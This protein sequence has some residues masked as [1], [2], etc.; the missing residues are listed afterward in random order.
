VVVAGST[1]AKGAR[2]VS[3]AEPI[4]LLGPP[5]PFASRGGHKLHAALTRFDVP[6]SGRRA[7]DLGAST[8]GFTDCLLQHGAA[9][10]YSVDVGHGQL[11]QRLRADSRVT[12]LERVNARLLTPALLHEADPDFEPCALVTADLS[13]ISL[14]T[15]TPTLCGPVGRPDADL[16]LLVKP[17]FEAGRG[18]V[19]RGRGV[20]RDPEVWLDVLAG[21]TSALRD[22]GTGI[23]GAMMSPLTGPAGNIEFL[24]HARKG[25]EG[26]PSGG[27]TALLSD[28]VSEAGGHP[29]PA[30]DPD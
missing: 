30:G 21:V 23:M 29:Q 9:H 5:S 17:Q 8:G 10:V 13:F 27:I 7:L 18:V 20:V 12:V 19:S 6:V 25:A 2:L 22:A 1:A 3:P 14:R 28:A 16:V 24:V 15:V 11:D 4:V 26:R